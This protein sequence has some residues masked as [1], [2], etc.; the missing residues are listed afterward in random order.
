MTQRGERDVLRF[1]EGQGCLADEF[2]AAKAAVGK[3]CNLLVDIDID[4]EKTCWVLVN[5][6]FLLAIEKMQK[7]SVFLEFVLKHRHDLLELGLYVHRFEVFGFLLTS[8][9]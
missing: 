7:P 5:D 1:A 6:A 4:I 9:A 3:F 8:W 2:L